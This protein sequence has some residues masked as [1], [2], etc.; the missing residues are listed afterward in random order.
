M[1]VTYDAQT[2]ILRIILNN[3]PIDESDENH[4]GV[5]LDYDIE[6]NIVG[7]EILSASQRVDNPLGVEYNITRI[8]KV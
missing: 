1:K 4:T 5:I 6:G 2:D 8:E 7:I 3:T